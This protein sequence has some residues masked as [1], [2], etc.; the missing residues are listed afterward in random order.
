MIRMFTSSASG[1]RAAKTSQF[2][3]SLLFGLAAAFCINNVSLS[4][5]T[6][7]QE[8]QNNG[9]AS[10][11]DSAQNAGS[12]NNADSTANNDAPALEPVRLVRNADGVPMSL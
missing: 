4:A 5:Q 7:A 9:S 8:P 3:L 2:A 11:D 1:V 10:A 12:N 6:F